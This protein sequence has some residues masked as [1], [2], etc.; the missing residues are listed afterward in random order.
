MATD[1]DM[2]QCRAMR[3]HTDYDAEV[4]HAELA[5]EAAI[6]AVVDRQGSKYAEDRA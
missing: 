1:M 5:E 6:E 3:G 2:A 4:D